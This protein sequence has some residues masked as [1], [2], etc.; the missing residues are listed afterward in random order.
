MIVLG[1]YDTDTINSLSSMWLC[2]Y[3]SENSLKWDCSESLSKPPCTPGSMP[4]ASSQKPGWNLNENWEILEY[5]YQN[6]FI[7]KRVQKFSCPKWSFSCFLFTSAAYACRWGIQPYGS[8]KLPKNF[9]M[10]FEPWRWS[11]AKWNESMRQNTVW[12]SFTQP[13]TIAITS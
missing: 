3:N 2:T 12:K 10:V 11:M 13:S 9:T 1:I 7:F 5:I 4:H 6:S 8:A